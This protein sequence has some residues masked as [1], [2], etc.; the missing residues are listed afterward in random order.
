MGVLHASCD[1][2]VITLRLLQYGVQNHLEA[3][4]PM[5]RNSF[6]LIKGGGKWEDMRIRAQL[7]DCWSWASSKRR[8]YKLWTRGSATIF[9]LHGFGHYLGPRCSWPPGASQTIVIVIPSPAIW[10]V[11]CKDASRFHCNIGVGHLTLRIHHSA[12]F[13]QP[14][15]KRVHWWHFLDRYWMWVV[16]ELKASLL[17]TILKK[18]NVQVPHEF[19]LFFFFFFRSYS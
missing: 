12:I 6:I 14:R 3:V 7:E 18:V 15:D 2:N 9:Y 16:I 13:A 17:P 11:R 19:L 8:D 4:L 1:K 5:R 10:R